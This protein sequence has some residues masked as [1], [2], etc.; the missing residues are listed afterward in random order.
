LV[1]KLQKSLSKISV[2]LEHTEENLT[3]TDKDDLESEMQ[4]EIFNC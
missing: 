2:E 3:Q 4:C 1:E